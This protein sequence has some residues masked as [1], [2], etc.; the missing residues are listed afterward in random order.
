MN[1]R[2]EK[3]RVSILVLALLLCLGL[4]TACGKDGKNETKEPTATVTPTNTATPSPTPTPEPW[5]FYE[6]AGEAD[7]YRVPVKEL[8]PG[9]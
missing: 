2:S 3:W 6:K 9:S 5:K 8:T 4:L 1:M 7:V